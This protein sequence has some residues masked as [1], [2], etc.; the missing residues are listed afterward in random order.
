MGSFNTYLRLGYE[1]ILSLNALDHILFVIVLMAAYQTR[2]WLRI[3]I[4][5]SLFTVGHMV[6]LV[7]A[8]YDLIKVDKEMVEFLIPFT[9]VFTA[10]YNLTSAGQRSQ[11]RFK[12]FLALVFGIIHGL[13]FS[14]YLGMLIM[15]DGDL[16]SALLPFSLGVE[17]GQLVVVFVTYIFML[18]LLVLMRKNARDWNLFIS[19]TAFGLSLIM[20]IENWPW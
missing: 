6:S 12:Y 10:L 14:S 13:G 16:W 7:T 2:Y 4:A 5:V 3:V 15:G 20:C 19:G 17:I 1:H 18:I 11:G 9:I 8:S